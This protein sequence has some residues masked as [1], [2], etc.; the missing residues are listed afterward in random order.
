MQKRYR[1][2]HPVIQAADLA[3]RKAY[4]RQPSLTADGTARKENIEG[5]LL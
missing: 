2:N 1:A 3:A 4:F 5:N